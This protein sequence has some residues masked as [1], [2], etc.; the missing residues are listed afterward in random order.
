MLLLLLPISIIFLRA[1][2]PNI[3][4]NA[5]EKRLY[6]FFCFLAIIFFVGLRSVYT[7]SMDTLMYSRLFNTANNTSRLSDFFSLN[8][9]THKNYLFEEGNF[10]LLVWLISRFTNS[11]KF[12][13]VI[14]TAIMTAC[15]FKF[16]SAHSEDFMLSCIIYICL[17]SMTFSMNGTRQALAMSICLLAY[18]FAAKKKFIPFILIVLLAMTFH[19]SAFV[20]LIVYPLSNFSKLHI[21]PLLV[22]GGVFFATSSRLAVIYDTIVGKDYASGESIEGGGFVTVAIYVLV[23]VL[24]L[25]FYKNYGAESKI[26]P[27]FALVFIGFIIYITRYFSAQIFERTSYYF[28][29]FVILL[30]PK[31]SRIFKEEDRQVYSLIICAFAITLFAYRLSSSSMQNYQLFFM[32]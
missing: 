4:T 19:I 11:V 10:F 25:L 16:I 23:L 1:F 7:G 2:T 31:L 5:Q 21:L 22:A 30:I 32:E 12:F 20:F 13:L 18:G 29:Y 8:E 17:G 15:V 14:I 26:Q 28:Y 9:I 6:I 24:V 3:S 27:L